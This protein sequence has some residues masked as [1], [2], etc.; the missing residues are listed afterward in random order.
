MPQREAKGKI[1]GPWQRRYLELTGHNR[2][3]RVVKLI[4]GGNYGEHVGGLA[5][6]KELHLLGLGDR[7]GVRGAGF[8]AQS[9]IVV[10]RRL[11]LL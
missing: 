4:E 2:L 9:N 11:R 10:E 7:T 8:Y 3:V 6:G 1:G 5:G